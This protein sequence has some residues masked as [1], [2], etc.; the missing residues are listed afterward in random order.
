ME[1]WK[2][3]SNDKP[4]ND[5]VKIG[6]YREGGAE[7]LHTYIIKSISTVLQNVLAHLGIEHKIN[8]CD[9]LKIEEKKST[10]I[11]LYVH[12]FPFMFEKK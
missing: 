2:V 1:M 8:V 5:T 10:K 4:L 7:I 3:T 11:H 6:R 9:K 12:V